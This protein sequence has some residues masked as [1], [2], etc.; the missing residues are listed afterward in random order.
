MPEATNERRDRA[1]SPLSLDARGASALRS[2]EPQEL[3]LRRR[4]ENFARC[5]SDGDGA[6][7]GA[8]EWRS[9]FL[10]FRS[11]ASATLSPLSHPSLASLSRI[12]L[13]SPDSA[14]RGR[15]RTA[16]ENEPR[17]LRGGLDPNCTP[18]SCARPPFRARARQK[19]RNRERD[20]RDEMRHG[21]GVIGDAEFYAEGA[22]TEEERVAST[23]GVWGSTIYSKMRPVRSGLGPTLALTGQPKLP[24]QFRN[25]V[26]RADF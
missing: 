15:A 1:R 12:P 16:R 19:V 10:F 3:W 23:W 20:P 7:R 13:S 9:R 4:L 5:D 6:T 14:K 2:L 22:L 25:D 17:G 26:A 21:P 8:R 11:K 18:L 24:Q